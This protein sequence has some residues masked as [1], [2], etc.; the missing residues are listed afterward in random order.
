MNEIVRIA[1]A[2][3]SK[4]GSDGT[5]GG[6]LVLNQPAVLRTIE[7]VRQPDQL[8]DFRQILNEDISFI[9]IGGD[10][11]MI[12]TDGGTIIVKGF[13][14]G[15]GGSQ[16][17][18][19]GDTETLSLDDFTSI[20]NLQVSDEIQT[21][22]GET[23]NLA[24]ELGDGP[25]GG[26]QTFEDVV[27]N[28]LG[29]GL[30]INDL[31]IGGPPG[32]RSLAA[33]D[34]ADPIVDTVPAF[35]N[36]AI[37]VD[38]DEA[39]LGNGTEPLP[40]QPLVAEGSLG[41]D[42]GDNAG[43]LSEISLEF[44]ESSL[45][46]GLT[47]DG[48]PLTLDV[49]DVPPVRAE[50]DPDSQKGQILIATKPDGEIV[51][52]VELKITGTERDFGGEY[53]I[54]LFGNLDHVGDG[55][56]EILPLVFEIIATDGDGDS[57]TNTITANVTDDVPEFSAAPEP[58]AVDEDDLLEE[59]GR[60]EDEVERFV[61]DITDEE[62]NGEGGEETEEYDL[63]P[64]F[65]AGE[66]NIVWGADDS[67][68]DENS[69][70]QVDDFEVEVEFDLDGNPRFVQDTPDGTGDRSVVF[71]VL[72]PEEPTEVPEDEEET[73]GETTGEEGPFD[74]VLNLLAV[75]VA[76]SS[77]PDFINITYTDEGGEKTLT[78][79]YSRGE[80]VTFELNAD[81]TELTASAGDREVF[82]V[83]LSDEET[84]GYIFELIDT[85]DHPIPGDAEEDLNFEFSFIAT[86]GDG[87]QIAN[88]FQVAVNDDTPEIIETE[89][90]TVEEEQSE[91][92]GDGIDGTRGVGD[93]DERSNRDI[94]TH[95]AE[96]SLGIDFGAD[97]G[98]ARTIDFGGLPVGETLEPTEIESIL[99]ASNADGSIPLS[100]FT[101]R[102]ENISYIILDGREGP[103]LV[104]F[105]G[106]TAPTRVPGGERG[107][108]D[109]VVFTVE[110]LD[111]KGRFDEGDGTYE[112]VLY[113]TLDHPG[114]I[115]GEE[116]LTLNIGFVAT[117][118]DKDPVEG[119]FNVNIIDDRPIAIGTVFARTVEEE[120][121]TP[122]GNEDTDSASLFGD[123]DSYSFWSG[124]FRD[125]TTDEV[126]ATLNIRW[127]G[128]DSNTV[129]NG[130]YDGTQEAGDRSV[131]FATGTGSERQLSPGEVGNILWASVGLQNLT[132]GG[133]TLVYTLS[134]NGTTLVAT[135]S[136][137]DPVF[138]V[139]L[140]D[141]TDAGSYH[142]RLQGPLDHPIAGE[143]TDGEDTITL[144]FRFT[145]RDGD[146]DASNARFRVNVTDDSPVVGDAEDGVVEEEQ[147]EV[148]GRGNEDFGPEGDE[149]NDEDDEKTTQVARGDLAI[150]WG[151]DNAD[152]TVGADRATTGNRSV[153]F[154]DDPDDIPVG[155]RLTDEQVND[156]IEVN[157]GALN[158]SDLTSRGDD[159]S[160]IIRQGSQGPVLLAYT[161]ANNIVFRV[162]LSDDDSG[163]YRFVLFNTLDHPTTGSGFEGEDTLNL[164]FNY[165]ATDSDGDFAS[166]DFNVGIIDDVPI[167]GGE[168]R[169]R[170]VEEEELAGG[171]E[172]AYP[173]DIDFAAFNNEEPLT[174][175][176]GESLRIR[177]GGDNTNGGRDGFRAGLPV[178]DDPTT[179]GDR[180]VIFSEWSGDGDVPL[181]IVSQFLEIRDANGAEVDLDKLTSRG[182]S[183]YF[184]LSNDGTILLAL[185]T[186]E[187]GDE[188]SVF[189]VGLSD[190]RN[191]SYEFILDD[192]L[193]HP[194][195]GTSPVDE[196]PLSLIFTY[197]A[198]DG[199]GDYVKNDFIV[200]VV[201]DSPLIGPADVH[202]FGDREPTVY[203]SGELNLRIPEQGTSG[204]ITST[205][206]VSEGGSIFDINVSM[207]L[208]HS[209][210]GD[211]DVVLFAPDGTPITLILADVQPGAA[212]GEIT[213][214]DDADQS[215]DDASEPYRGTWRPLDSSDF[216]D[217]NFVDLNDAE[218]IDQAGT[219]TLEIT[220]VA[221]DDFGVLQSWS[222]EIQTGVAAVVDEDDLST[223][224]GDL[225][226]GIGDTTQNGD[227][228]VITNQRLENLYGDGDPT[229]VFGNLGIAWGADNANDNVNGGATFEDGDRGVAFV[230]TTDAQDGTIDQLLAQGFSSGGTFLHYE[231]TENGTLL[232]ARAGQGGETVFTVTLSD[233]HS[234]WF[235]FDLQGNLDHPEGADENN[236]IID[237]LYQAIDS[238]GDTAQATFSIGVDDDSPVAFE[239][240]ETTATDDDVFD[241]N[242]GG[243][244]DVDDEISVSGNPGALFNAGADGVR[245]V[246]I[247]N[248]PEV[249]AIYVDANGNGI[250]QEAS[251]SSTTTVGGST[252][253][254][255]SSA[256]VTP[257][258]TLEIF[259]DGSYRFTQHGP[260]AHTVSGES[261]EN[262]ELEFAFIV[263][264]GDGDT[265][266]GSLTVQVNDDT[267][268]ATLEYSGVT[269][270]LAVDETPG[271]Q[272]NDEGRVGPEDANVFDG[273]ANKGF[274][275]DMPPQFGKD[276]TLF[277]VSGSSAG[278]DG[279]GSAVF[280]LELAGNGTTNLFTSGPD[281][282]N[283]KLFE[284]DDGYIVGRYNVDGDEVGE[285]DPAAFAFFVE[286][287]TG[288]AHIA[289]FV[290]LEH[291]NKNNPDDVLLLPKNLV[292]VT[293]TVTD[294]DGDS[295]TAR[296]DLG[297]EARFY[298]DGP[299]V[300]WTPSERTNNFRIISDDDTVGDPDIGNP[301][302]PDDSGEFHQSGKTL[303]ISFGADGG[304]VAWDVSTSEGLAGIAGGPDSI[305]FE[306]VA[307]STDAD[308]SVLLLKQAQG[309]PSVD[310]TVAEVTLNTLTGEYSYEQVA[311]L[312][313]ADGGNENDATFNLGFLVTDGD[314]DSVGDFI[315][316]II[317]DD[318]PIVDWTPSERTNN[319]RIISD[320]DTVGDP[321]IGNP[322]GPDDSGEFHQ[323]GKT[324]PISFG[325]DGG[326][327][328]WDVSTSEGL[329]GIAGGPDSISFE[330]VAHSTDADKSVLLLKQAQGDPSVD[331]TVAEVTLNTLTGEYSY[332]QVANLLHADGGN[333]ND[334]TFNLGFLVTDGD[335][336]SV[337]DF[338]PLIIDDDS[339]TIR[340]F[341]VNPDRTIIAEG[342]VENGTSNDDGREFNRVK[343]IDFSVGADGAAE[344]GAVAWDAAASGPTD[345]S[346]V[347]FSFD[348]NSDGTLLVYQQQGT[349]TVLVAEV[350]MDSNTGRYEV[351]EKANVL[352]TG[353]NGNSASLTL[354]FT[355]TDGDG[356]TA[357]GERLLVLRD[358]TPSADDDSAT[359]DED[360]AVV[361]SVLANDDAGADGIDWTDPANVRIVTGPANGLISY[362]NDGTF[363]YTPSADYNGSDSFTYAV[364]D[365]DG[366][367]TSATV[368]VTV[369]PVNDAPEITSDG[370]GDTATVNVDE[371][372]TDVTTVTSSDVDGG[373]PV[374]SILATADTDHALFDIDSSTGKLTFKSAPD[375]ENP[376]DVGGTNGD[377]AYVVDVQVSDGN[378][379]TD[380]Q[381][382]TVN[383]QDVDE[384][385]YV[386]FSGTSIRY[387]WNYDTDF[388]PVQTSAVGAG[389][390]FDTSE[391][392][393][394]TRSG[395]NV[396][397]NGSVI[398]IDYTASAS[399]WER[400]SWISDAF[401]G[402]RLTDYLGQ[403]QSY[404]GIEFVS[405]NLAGIEANRITV[406]QDVISV[407]WRGL[408]P[409]PDTI[410][411]FKVLT[412]NGVNDPIAL[413]LNG[414]GVDLSASVAFDI[415][416]DGDL[417]E[418]GWV[419]PEDG[420]LVVDV[421]GSGAI[422]DG[423]EVF[424]EVFNG[425]S[426][427]DSLE[428]LATLDSN[429]DGVIDANDA[430]FGD[431]MVWQDANSDGITQEGELQTLIERG[432]SAIDLEAAR[433]DQNVDG[434]T[435]FAEGTYTNEDGSTGTYV[436][437]NFGA[438]N[439][440][441]ADSEETTRQSTAIAA[442]IA[443]VLYTASA[444]EVA[445]G[446]TGI[447]VKGD[448]A[449]GIVNVDEDLSAIYTPAA[450]YSGPDA[451]ELELVFADGT[452]VT[453]TIELE[454][455]ADEAAVT[456]S[457]TG[458]A[459]EVPGT[460]Q[461][462]ADTSDG[463]SG[464]PAASPAAVTV[465][466]S[467]IR[468]DDG[469]NIL[470]G[471]DGDDILIG[472]LGSDTLT[473]GEGADTFVLNSLAEADI[474]TDYTFGEGDK[475]DLGQ[476][477]DS[478][479][480][481]A[482]DAA[483]FVRAHRDANGEVRVEV[484]R[485]GGRDGEH[486]WQEAATLQDHASMGDTVRV[487]LD[488]EGTETNIAVNVA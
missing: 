18:L 237:F 107:D 123:L 405:S 418:I 29:P 194:L 4:G 409:E 278:A 290:S 317:D 427:A 327:V 487:V 442:G 102:G 190:D 139:S 288:I 299:E 281:R 103:I 166:G 147:R 273:V 350:T 488:T 271:I 111:E 456:T 435:V 338:I 210:M 79:L 270:W 389:V 152:D 12:F 276:P 392:W 258:L 259:N 363:T 114:E 179:E 149:D 45:P 32:I 446:L 155:T 25:S 450:G 382:L 238:D 141:V 431:I 370:G 263:T 408:D 39:N 22:A 297:G 309:D 269:G 88:T 342:T 42:F 59:E 120:Q 235:K 465:T 485:D 296:L 80:L 483:E 84:G 67:D 380:V 245:S 422:E 339:P 206:E 21:A 287:D 90:G 424:S 398:T 174:D 109:N 462:V 23:T 336:D 359:T 108:S 229:V 85:L 35:L 459:L 330:V 165:H 96:G 184:E 37:V 268:E 205:I 239:V 360:T 146:G 373:T 401:N 419:G 48:E 448:A 376:T 121:L 24:T 292:N 243:T 93:D 19:V 113:D 110:L 196:D 128:D 207:V 428:A 201:D 333:E 202:E 181:N 129:E 455:L 236:L 77:I 204:T 466:G 161:L 70:V 192:T 1:Q 310:V 326:T 36:G 343:T 284:T 98:D 257:V 94:T 187:N 143:G 191:G 255:A 227:D 104:A 457:V 384:A 188:R 97:D 369:D 340:P 65:A 27:I 385:S 331:V 10:L 295:S 425:G 91:V 131:V 403:H 433:V 355:V 460:E 469:D 388:E 52:T 230:D 367:E 311:N 277:D 140:S 381:Q 15:D 482:A 83:T 159:L 434:N 55:L 321:D 43:P 344:G 449:N 451:V 458:E 64:G 323:S 285:N 253:W 170:A 480:G 242:E 134:A 180:S 248:P 400:F 345:G 86:D 156:L 272:R 443:L 34:R 324:L 31:L 397:I 176:V 445:A 169:T 172:D 353:T 251:W 479:F 417:D 186:D 153:S 33:D 2:N 61:T 154:G 208:W 432:I 198:R 16:V 453:R 145:A 233:T 200:Q 289:Q 137:G 195:Q 307:H 329:A 246:E 105:T 386:D 58:G 410:I 26:G 348:T 40:G 282:A 7:V 214:D 171:N 334:A 473:G 411:Q 454:V 471:T 185:A 429:G 116:T 274:D 115:Q 313:H 316:L 430:A 222:L 203:D 476:L 126:S 315:P 478:A 209:Y 78:E 312:L 144:A 407:D 387:Q 416:A 218:G 231:I 305:S 301:G 365:G 399:P 127:G 300:D 8:V 30:G 106:N 247:A 477:L 197:T 378:G 44:V 306:V 379:G 11:Q 260:L 357:V 72:A 217:A 62:G 439:D 275:P 351:T 157:D 320:D 211:L 28:D 89:D 475:L 468:G 56:G 125:R 361:I 267:P 354:K 484:D 452:T 304:T 99:S 265:A 308:K 364:K 225:V 441:A 252:I 319:F 219:W 51:F 60:G 193:D 63:P 160:F 148:V 294:G 20:A 375:Y 291:S 436:G 467:V 183:V 173:L 318:S 347:G 415:D 328:A 221:S 212:R 244:G 298:D 461:D 17:A 366:D 391:T 474:I 470:V 356:D 302:G 426:Y 3:I 124:G 132:S 13:F 167:V 438:A 413:D 150:S 158:A 122:F 112:F 49:F 130:G 101:S 437:V 279:I 481:A 325:A 50:S 402:F 228:D 100:E 266:E 226:D 199:D 394:P 444:E 421:D 262:Q 232:T 47:S 189:R 423:S 71:G 372:T 374:Y 223:Q 368:S 119:D 283:I 224:N 395:W 286:P 162:S 303:P 81:G 66:L 168:V 215:F 358:D 464:E 178:Q 175:R 46:T 216:P 6:P 346:A 293:Y 241:G 362:N 182:D 164:T 240:S 412:T 53:E 82:R 420:L 463:V 220:D 163:S 337:G 95:R 177:W 390:E 69:E 117:D 87:D 332:E 472:G 151:A 249:T 396:D 256:N 250:E 447:N 57:T 118:G 9:R 75:E 74:T 349:E 213:L 135:T 414:D 138:T 5:D 261:E 68:K 14:D 142:F 254:T 314:G 92:V 393:V 404:E 486:D 383:V 352:H 41:L 54:K 377:N 234:G 280:G 341:D 136:G 133:E 335:G 73:G 440:D 38:F 76:Q 322:G 406:T 371:N 264:D